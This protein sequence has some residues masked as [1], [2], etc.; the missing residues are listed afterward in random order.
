MLFVSNSMVTPN[1]ELIIIGSILKMV[2]PITLM[3]TEFI[4]HALVYFGICS[5]FA[6]VIMN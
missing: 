1:I 5:G 2:N 3:K 6:S 4:T